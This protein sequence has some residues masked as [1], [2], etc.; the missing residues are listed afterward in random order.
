MDGSPGRPKQA[1]LCSPHSPLHPPSSFLSLKW[2][3]CDYSTST[4]RMSVSVSPKASE[5]TCGHGKEACWPL[6][7]EN[8]KLSPFLPFSSHK[9]SHHRA[10]SPLNQMPGCYLLAQQSVAS[11]P[12]ASQWCA[13]CANMNMLCCIGDHASAGPMHRKPSGRHTLAFVACCELLALLRASS[14]SS[15]PP[16]MG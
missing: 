8:I 2:R 1:S 7:H 13:A 12:E 5:L 11:P 10:A 14:G 16:H 6:A 3:L 15:P 4:T 9:S